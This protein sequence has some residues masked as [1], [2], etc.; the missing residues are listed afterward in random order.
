MPLTGGEIRLEHSHGGAVAHLVIDHGKYNV[1]TMET[2]RVMADRFA[3][4]D[5][6]PQVHVVV[7]RAEGEH[8]TS[9]GD[10]AGFMEVEPVE[11]T[12]LGQDVT[13]AARSPKPVVVA[14]DGYC[15][16]V[17]LELALSADIR[18]ATERS[19]FALPEMKLGMIPGSGG[20]QRLARLVGL[21]R[22]KYHVLT[23]ER[24]TGQQA[25]DWGL[26]ARCCPD[27]D[28]L[29][30]ALEEVVTTLL[31]HSPLAMRTAKEVLD[32]GVDGPLYTGI[33]LER[34]AYSMLR[35][36]HDFAEGV[37]AFGEKRTPQFEGR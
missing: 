8:F 21:S 36:S 12:D 1:I 14:V 27:A 32:R 34:K 18:L 2:R 11:L 31:R 23:G 3:E 19:R 25:Y 5:A 29:S 22:A 6:D 24:I 15:F 13:A 4:V 9:G 37:A 17:G 33:E 28:A 26:V 20:T 30:E 10:I 35:A 7:I 16:G